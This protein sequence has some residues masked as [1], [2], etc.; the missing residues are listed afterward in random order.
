MPD[1]TRGR[2]QSLTFSPDGKVLVP[3]GWEVE[4]PIGR[5]KWLTKFWDTAVGAERA[6]RPGSVS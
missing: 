5:V 6:A 3:T 1:A 2:V 4:S